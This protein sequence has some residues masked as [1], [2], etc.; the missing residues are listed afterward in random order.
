M[1]L[2]FFQPS[3]PPKVCPPPKSNIIFKPRLEHRATKPQPFSL[4]AKE[5]EARKRKAELVR[6]AEEEARKVSI[7]FDEAELPRTGLSSQSGT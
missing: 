3:L 2:I 7:P 6:L 4:E 1:L 5:E